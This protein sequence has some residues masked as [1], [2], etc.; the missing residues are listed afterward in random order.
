MLAALLFTTHLAAKR[1]HH[2]AQE[3]IC[4]G[5]LAALQR[6]TKLVDNQ[7][8][9][10]YASLSAP[11]LQSSVAKYSSIWCTKPTC[12]CHFQPLKACTRALPSA[13]PVWHEIRPFQIGSSIAC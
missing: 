5:P 12:W 13:S 10:R 2:I 6:K 11:A 7:P 3:V 8:Q 1:L 4:Q 9:C